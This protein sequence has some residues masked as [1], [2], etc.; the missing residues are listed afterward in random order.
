VELSGSIDG[1][2]LVLRGASWRIGL[3]IFVLTLIAFEAG[4]LEMSLQYL[5]LRQLKLDCM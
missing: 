4:L 2:N 3:L 5:K 1:G